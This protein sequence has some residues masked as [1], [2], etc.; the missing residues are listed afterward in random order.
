MALRCRVPAKGASLQPPLCSTC[1]VSKPASSSTALRTDAE[2]DAPSRQATF[3][4]YFDLSE[5]SLDKRAADLLVQA[6][7]PQPPSAPPLPPPP[8][9]APSP[10]SETN[11]SRGEQAKERKGKKVA[12]P[13]DD[14]DDDESEDGA[15]TGEAGAGEPAEPVAEAAGAAGEP[16]QVG[17]GDV[18]QEMEKD[19]GVKAGEEEGEEADATAREALF[20]SAP[21]LKE[22]GT[23]GA[24]SV[25]SLRLENCG[26]RGPA[27]EA[28][29]AWSSLLA[30]NGRLTQFKRSERHPRERDQAHLAA[31]EPH[32]RCRR[33]Q[34]RRHHPRLP[35]LV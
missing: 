24:A 21:L 25:L 8:P 35:A 23:T 5:T 6:L 33:R 18:A 10:P 9:P 32:Q 31:Q 26:I 19:Q 30:F 29:G 14:D 17:E 4:R 7:A 1:S 15:A 28:L 3:L 12:G 22:D 27:L 16:T 13:W 34:P 20:Q 11:G 2:V